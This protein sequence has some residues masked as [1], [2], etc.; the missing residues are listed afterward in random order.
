MRGI[1]PSSTPSDKLRPEEPPH[2]SGFAA[3][4]L[5]RGEKADAY[6]VPSKLPPSEASAFA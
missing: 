2:P 6:A 5:P 1:A 4:L 3:H